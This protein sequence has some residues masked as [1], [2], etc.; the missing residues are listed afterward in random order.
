MYIDSAYGQIQISLAKKDAIEK[1]IVDAQT[2]KEK[3]EHLAAVVS[4]FP[5][6]YQVKLRALL[7]DSIDPTRLIIEVNAMA[8]SNGLH[9][10]TPTVAVI[11]NTKK[12]PL[13]YVRHTV[14]FTVRTTYSGFRTFLRDLEGNLSLRDV[15]SL[16]F[17]SQETDQDALQYRSPEL[18]PHDYTVV[19]VTY[20]LH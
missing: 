1:S 8:V 4:G 19:L 10:T 15:S 12:T 3:I 20:S 11:A 16:S 5:Q 14:T 17:N 2:A 9:I 18:V 7:P 13:P 6:D